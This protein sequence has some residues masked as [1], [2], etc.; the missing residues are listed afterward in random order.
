M[1]KQ[2][3]RSKRRDGRADLHL[4]GRAGRQ[5]PA[6]SAAVERASAADR[7]YFL[8]HPGQASY[9]RALVPGE[10]GEQS[11]AHLLCGLGL[12]AIDGLEGEVMVEVTQIRPG[13]RQRRPAYVLMER[14][15]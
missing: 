13:A 9:L 14:A 6:T 12:G 3:R 1:G 11:R 15:S 2:S 5:R 10:F 8:A 4:I 7:A